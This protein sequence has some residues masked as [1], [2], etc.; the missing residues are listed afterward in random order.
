MYSYAALAARTGYSAPKSRTRFGDTVWAWLVG[1]S[2]YNRPHYHVSRRFLCL[3]P[4]YSQDKVFFL[5][6]L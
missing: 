1:F 2:G 5:S 3:E 6:A 4:F